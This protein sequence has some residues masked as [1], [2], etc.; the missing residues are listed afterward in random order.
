MKTT[1]QKGQGFCGLR[2]CFPFSRGRSPFLRGCLQFLRGCLPYVPGL[3]LFLLPTLGAAQRTEVYADNIA[4]VRVGVNGDFGHLPVARLGSDDV[5]QVAFDE[6]SHDFHR[7]TYRIVHLDATFEPTESLFESDYLD[8]TAE[9]GVVEDYEQSMNT[10]VLYTHYRISLPN[11]YMRPLL[12]GNYALTVYDDADTDEP[13]ALLKVFFHVVEDGAAVSA[14]GTTDTDI[15]RN[16]THQQIDVSLSWQKDLPLRDPDTEIYLIVL[17]ND[18]WQTAVRGV[19]S[20]GQ[21]VGGLSWTHCRP[22]IFPA[23]NEYRKFEVP[24][25]RYPGMHVNAV[26][27]HAP[28]YHVELMPDAPRRNYL[29]DEDQNGRYV[30]L[31]DRGGDPETEAEYV[32]VHFTVDASAMEATPALTL[33]GRWVPAL[34]ADR[35]RLEYHP[36]RGAYTAALFLKQGYYSYRYLCTPAPQV[37]EGDYWQTEN[38]YTLLVYYRQTGARYD[39]LIAHRTA[40]YRPR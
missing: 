3:F 18:A 31:S 12:S 2:G 4:T 22:L 24:S 5:V 23:G 20:T 10:S 34:P 32:R 39:R 13:Q 1:G 35:Y 27:Y 26:S 11:D 25:T 19:P 8:A 40:S 38:E 14:S 33:D 17:Q 9:E 29:Y 16:G 30:P 36:D 7:Y 28:Y 21:T 37:V 6:L 15:D